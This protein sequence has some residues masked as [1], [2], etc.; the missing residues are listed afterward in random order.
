MKKLDRLGWAEGIGMQ[1]FGV[2]AGVRVNSVGILPQVL[3]LLPPGWKS[4]RKTTVQRL[5]SLVVA[6]KGQ[7]DRLRRLHI[8]Y[9]DGERIAR[10]TELDPVLAAL[11]T[12]LHRYV[13]E[14]SPDMTF[15][16]AGVVG[17]Q[18]RAILLPGRSLCG[19]S[20]LVRELLRRGATYYSDE[21]AVVDDFGKI[22]PFPRPLGIREDSTFSQTR[23][24]A[25]TWGATSGI[26][27]LALGAVVICK[28]RAG[29]R[30]KPALLSDGAGALQLMANS[31][32]VRNN[33]RRT[34]RRIQK[35]VKSAVFVKGTRGEAS[36]SAESILHLVNSGDRQEQ[37]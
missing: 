1:A 16:H 36:E 35:L 5:Y 32:A 20:T 31:I 21:F 10:N 34:L 29:A 27:P 18:G 6:K 26:K 3:P 17:W 30:W 11:E 25:A 37:A 28:Y 24:P 8:L 19:K 14:T 13:A 12:D 4:F 7:D 15:L 2:Q 23:Y 9:A 22:H 33:P